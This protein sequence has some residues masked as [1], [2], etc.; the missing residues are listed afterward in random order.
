MPD[1]RRWVS[2]C[3][4]CET[5][6]ITS[7]IEIHRTDIDSDDPLAFMVFEPLNPVT[8]GHQLVV[9]VDH[10]PHAAYDTRITRGAM[11]V[12]AMLLWDLPAGNIITSKGSA[13]T[14]TVFH[15]H[16]HVVPRQL[17]D[18]LHLP[19]TGQD[20]SQTTP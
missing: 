10:V 18:G 13:A 20:V 14:Q 2:G 6:R 5:S 9:P 11:Q 12:A 15:F 17:G 1:D 7:P 4:F 19:W 8:P 3:V 16:V